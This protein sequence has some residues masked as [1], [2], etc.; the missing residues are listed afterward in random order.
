MVVRTRDELAAVV[1]LNPLGEVAVEPE[2]LPGQLPLGGADPAL[3]RE[4]RPSWRRSR[5][6]SPCRGREV[7]AWHP[8]G[9]A[10]SKLWLAL[11]GSSPELTATARNWTTVTQSAN[12]GG[13][14]MHPYVIADVFTDVPLEGNQLAV[15]LDGAGLDAARCSG[16]RVS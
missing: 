15:F 13:R 7:Y 4:A 12:D 2:A 6:A 16:P 1:A 3:V 5:S 14:V 8:E 9:V 11:A 10:R